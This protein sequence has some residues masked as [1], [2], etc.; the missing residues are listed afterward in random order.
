MITYKQGHNYFLGAVPLKNAMAL[1]DIFILLTI[2]DSMVSTKQNFC[3][4]VRIF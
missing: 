3:V 1:L 4:I 2:N